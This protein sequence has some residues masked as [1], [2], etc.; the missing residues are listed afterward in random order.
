M[1]SLRKVQERARTTPVRGITPR[2]RARKRLKGEV[3]DDTPQKE[4]RRQRGQRTVQNGADNSAKPLAY[5]TEEASS[6]DDLGPSPFKAATPSRQARRFTSLLEPDR[7]DTIE[8]GPSSGDEVDRYTRPP[9]EMLRLFTKAVK[10]DGDR[11]Q[12]THAS[13]PEADPTANAGTSSITGDLSET[14]VE[15]GTESVVSASE[16]TVAEEVTPG[17]KQTISSDSGLRSEGKQS[18]RQAASRPVKML[19]ISDGEE[20]EW[21]PEGGHVQHRVA[22]VPT[23]ARRHRRHRSSESALSDYSAASADAT[24]QEDESDEGDDGEPPDGPILGDDKSEM[25]TQ[26]KFGFLSLKSP[27]KKSKGTIEALRVQ[28]LFSSTAAARLR[29]MERG[30]EVY[31]SGEVANE[32]EIEGMETGVMS[33]N[34]AG[35]DDWESENEGWK[36]VVDEEQW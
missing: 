36:A 33:M 6:D 19:S 1:N 15:L 28:A 27:T 26:Q 5:R 14:L 32:D 7:Q 2:T 35:D 21:D 18:S 9:N 12:A 30:Q 20:D 34:E 29:A 4:P 23:R 11:E 8:A 16:S 10:A 24:N 13:S 3:V 22:I 17:D 31:V 25:P